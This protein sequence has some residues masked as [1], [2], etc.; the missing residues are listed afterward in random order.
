MDEKISNFSDM[1]E[2]SLS[3]IMEIGNILSGSYVSAISAITGLD[4]GLSTPQVAI[5]M[6]GRDFKL[7]GSPFRLHGGQAAFHRRGFLQRI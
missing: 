1:S 5:D 2:I 3:A 6:A 7:P 4:I